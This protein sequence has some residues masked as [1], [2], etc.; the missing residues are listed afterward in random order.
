VTIAVVVL[1]TAAPRYQVTEA[2]DLAVLGIAAPRYQAT[3]AFDLAVLGIA[4]PRYQATEAFNLTVLGRHVNLGACVCFRHPN[5][6]V[7]EG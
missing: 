2:F 3:E 5:T 1:A 4:A 6:T 7:R